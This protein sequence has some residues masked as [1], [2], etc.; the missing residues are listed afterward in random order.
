MTAAHIAFIGRRRVSRYGF[1]FFLW[2]PRFV[3]EI[4][5]L[6]CRSRSVLGVES[7]SA[8]LLS[9]GAPLLSRSYTAT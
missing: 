7:E 1:A 4:A 5:S 6:A 3:G 8:N 2:T 9:P